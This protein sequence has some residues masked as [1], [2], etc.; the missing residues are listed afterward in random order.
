MTNEA[1]RAFLSALRTDATL[2]GL[3]AAD[4]TD[5]SSPAIFLY[6]GALPP[7]YP[8]VTYRLADSTPDPAF[9]PTNAEGGGVGTI[10]EGRAELRIYAK[11]A[12]H[13]RDAIA[14][15]VRNAAE[16]VALTRAGWTGRLFRVEIVTESPD[17]FDPALDDFY[18]LIRFRLRQWTPTS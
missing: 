2:I 10:A 15:A 17:N 9:R 14:E 8:S 12:V 1:R 4:P 13:R 11:G 5:G 3:L 18:H 6:N 7:V 16:G